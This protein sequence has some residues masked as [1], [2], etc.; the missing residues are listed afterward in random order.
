MSEFVAWL[1]ST[2]GFVGRWTCGRWSDLHGWTH[3]IADLAVFGAYT[4]IPIVL[5]YFISRRKDVPFPRV[6]WLFGAFILSCGFTHLIEAIIFWHPIY[7]FSAAVKV[8]TAIV[9]WLTVFALVA[10]IPTALKL[11]GLFRLNAE[12]AAANERLRLDAEER[13]RITKELEVA[14]EQAEAA[15]HAKSDFLAHMSHEIRTPLAAILGFS[16]LL[17]ESLQAAADR[18]AADAIKR[19]GSHLLTLL[20]DVLDLS[21]IESGRL[22]LEITSCSLGEVIE[23]CVLIVR[24]G[25]LEKGID[26]SVE[27]QSELPALVRSDPTRL[28][29]V[30]LNLLSNAVKFTEKGYVR[31]RVAVQESDDGRTFVL[32]VQDSGI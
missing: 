16:G 13:D 11:P 22:S 24:P 10:I 14:R 4:A 26:F 1:F 27:G 29:Q 7:P 19:N 2:D 18:E 9:S 25:A 20:N 21:R 15:N 8:T 5:A 12:L 31:L 6:F 23:D 28:R 30:V 32:E 3:I 17:A